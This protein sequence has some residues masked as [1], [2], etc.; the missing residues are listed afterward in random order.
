MSLREAIAE[1]E[2]SYG[3]GVVA[4]GSRGRTFVTKRFQTMCFDFDLC[5]GGGMPWGKFIM[6]YGP[7]SGGKTMLAYKTIAG[8]QQYCR[9]CR[10]MF[11][12]NAQGEEWCSCAVECGTCNETYEKTPYDGP[13]AQPD[14]PF[15]WEAVHDVWK[16]G[17]LVNPKGTKAKK[18]RV[19]KTIRMASMSRQALFDAE[20]SFDKAWAE[21]LGINTDYLFVFV[22]EYAEQGIDIADHL[23]RSEEID[24]LAID[25]VAELTPSKEIEASTEEWQMGLQARLVNKAL[26]KWNSSINKLG[27]NATMLPLVILINQVRSNIGGYEDVVPGGKGQV[28]KSSIRVRVN[29]AQYK[30]KEQGSGKDKIKELLYADMSGFTKKNKT[31]PPMKKYSLRLYLDEYEGHPKGSTNEYGVVATRAIEYGIIDRPDKKKAIYIYEEGDFKFKWTSQKQVVQEMLKNHI[32]FWA[33]RDATMD[34][35]LELIR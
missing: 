25:S 27:A 14:D 29:P 34:L 9:Y 35:A 4:Q 12:V 26:R 13:K 2:S 22:P 8:A 33:I 11:V 16:C 31:A 15:D 6:F 32:L 10:G 24:I 19:P 3:E 17:C 20:N 30:F 18:D 7:E 21:F 23:L 28:Y 1:I 5:I